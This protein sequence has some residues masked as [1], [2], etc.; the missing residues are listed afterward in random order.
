MT[1]RPWHRLAAIA[2]AAAIACTVATLAPTSAHAA[3][4]CTW[5]PGEVQ[6]G[7]DNGVPLCEQCGTSGS[8]GRAPSTPD[9][10]AVA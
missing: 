6:V 1:I 10:S 2:K 7:E 3:F 9:Y 8:Q 4:P 5:A